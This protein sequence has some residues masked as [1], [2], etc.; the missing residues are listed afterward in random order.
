MRVI[1]QP[2]FLVRKKDGSIRMVVDSRA[3]NRVT[4]K[5]CC[6]MGNIQN[7]LDSV[8]GSKIFSN[9]DLFSGYHNI[10]IASEDRPKTAFIVPAAPG[11][12]GDLFQFI[13]VCFGLTNAPATFCRVVDRIFGDIKQKF[14]LLYIMIFSFIQKILPA[15]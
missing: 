11:F 4:V 1:G 12:S 5:D 8:Y 3:L 14:C 13:R 15:T 9:M 10:P 7:I 2:M 6:P